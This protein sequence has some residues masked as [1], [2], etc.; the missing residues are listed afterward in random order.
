MT[1]E[2]KTGNIFDSGAQVLVNPVN[3]VGVMGKGLALE[4]KERFPWM[5][6]AY[7]LDCQRGYLTPGTTILVSN[8]AERPA[9]LLF[10]TKDHW[11]HP[12]KLEWIE[13]GLRE[14]V[15]RTCNG[16]KET[17]AMPWLGC[18]LGGLRRADVRGLYNR[19]LGPINL[20][21]TVYTPE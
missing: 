15:L 12:S 4:F 6:N 8:G 1:V 13:L 17:V 10:A 3:C 2:Y 19:I 11:R 20:K 18:G 14:I 9:V 7:L 16:W 5:W 21:V